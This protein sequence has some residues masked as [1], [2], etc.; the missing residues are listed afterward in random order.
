MLHSDTF[1][2]CCPH[3]SEQIATG[4]SVVL[5]LLALGSLGLAASSA[6][7]EGHGLSSLWGGYG[8]LGSWAALGWSGLGPGAMASYLHVAG[9]RHVAPAEAQIIFS[10]KP[11]WAAGLAWLLLGGENLGPQ[12]WAGGAALA[13]AGLVAAGGGGEKK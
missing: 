1:Q 12:S 4:K 11:L 9:Q 6:A 2:P 8:D 7:A 5:G 3:S 10:S 13:A